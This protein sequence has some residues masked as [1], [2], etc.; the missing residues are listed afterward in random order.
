M[1]AFHSL[2]CTHFTLA[3]THVKVCT[4]VTH[5]HSISLL[6]NMQ[7]GNTA[8]IISAK[9]GNF[10]AMKSLLQNG[11]DPTMANMVRGF[12]SQYC[13]QM[14]PSNAIENCCFFLMQ[15]GLKSLDFAEVGNY[16]ECVKLLQSALSVSVALSSL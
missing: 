5:L 11:A 6:C 14:V 2:S 10:E 8:L 12:K 16:K 9:L 4:C 13:G 7:E 15:K 1:L 3:H